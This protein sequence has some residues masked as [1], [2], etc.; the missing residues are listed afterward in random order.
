MRPFC[1]FIF[2]CIQHPGTTIVTDSVTSDGLT[3][4]IENKLGEF[5]F[6]CLNSYLRKSHNLMGFKLILPSFSQEVSITGL[7]E[8]IKMSLMKAFVW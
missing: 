7:K 8:D 2:L 1:L 6:I 4:F 5:N 3:T